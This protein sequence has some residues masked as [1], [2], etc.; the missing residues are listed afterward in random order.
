[1]RSSFTCSGWTGT[2]R[3]GSRGETMESPGPGGPRV[4]SRGC[5]RRAVRARRRRGTQ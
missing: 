2:S 1:M 5:V 4:P 3:Q